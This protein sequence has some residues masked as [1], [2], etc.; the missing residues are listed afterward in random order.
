MRTFTVRDLDRQPAKV[1]AAC[2][3]EGAVRIRRRNGHTYTLRPDE[4]KRSRVSSEARRRW[5]EEHFRWLERTFPKPI[6]T[7]QTALVDRLVAGE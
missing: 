5:L 7:A 2:D 3:K 6:S 1:L 4:P